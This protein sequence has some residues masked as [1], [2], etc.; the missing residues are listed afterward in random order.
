MTDDK[1]NPIKVDIAD[2]I[3]GTAPEPPVL[4]TYMAMGYIRDQMDGLLDHI[5][6][7]YGNINE[8]GLGDDTPHGQRAIALEKAYDEL[9]DTLGRFH[10]N[11]EKRG[12]K[13]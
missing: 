4:R 2:I 10:M 8:L 13:G 11:D 9:A 12:S 6:D 5:E 1:D 7:V 3:G